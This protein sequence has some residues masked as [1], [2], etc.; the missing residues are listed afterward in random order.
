MDNT[1]RECGAMTTDGDRASFDNALWHPACLIEHLTVEVAALR[2]C[3][4]LRGTKLELA[5]A[6]NDELQ[7]E[8]SRRETRDRSRQ[9]G[10]DPA[11]VRTHALVPKDVEWIVNDLGELGVHV[12]DLFV[13]LYKGCS[14]EYRDGKHDSGQ[15]MLWR[16]VGKREF[17]EICHPNGWWNERGELNTGRGGPNADGIYREGDGWQALPARD[18]GERSRSAGGVVTMT[19]RSDDE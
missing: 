12:G 15:P 9:P 1:C 16:R 11:C 17:G 7:L 14:I 2:E 8:L 18:A 4:E 19:R 10:G 6:R 5:A 13:F 3:Y